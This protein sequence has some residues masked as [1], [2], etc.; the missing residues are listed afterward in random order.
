[1]N[2]DLILGSSFSEENSVFPFDQLMTSRTSLYLPVPVHLDLG[3]ATGTGTNIVTPEV[4]AQE[5]RDHHQRHPYF[6]QHL[7]GHEK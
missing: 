3:L 7:L 1:M 5:D 6:P 4:P 2:H